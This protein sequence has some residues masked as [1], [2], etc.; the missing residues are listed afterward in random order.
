MVS[1]E[2]L[3]ACLFIRYILRSILLKQECTLIKVDRD[4]CLGA[5]D[6][7]WITKLSNAA[8]IFIMHILLWF[9]ANYTA[10]FDQSQSTYYWLYLAL[11]RIFGLL[12]IKKKRFY[13]FQFYESI[14][15]EI[16]S[17]KIWKLEM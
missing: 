13:S 10:R 3:V 4:Q 8:P 11:D 7:F 5:S 14:L 16:T 12:W 6:L 15:A 9:P 1:D 2:R 17:C